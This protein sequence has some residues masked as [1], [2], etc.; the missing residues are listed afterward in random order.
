MENKK[1]LKL[2]YKIALIICSVLV[3]ANLVVEIVEMTDITFNMVLPIIGIL[4]MVAVL[5]Y[6]YIG[7]K[8][9]HGNLLRNAFF[10]YA[11]LDAAYIIACPATAP[12]YMI[13]IFMIEVVLITYMSGRLNKLNQ[14]KIIIAIVG[15]CTLVNGVCYFVR[16]PSISIIQLFHAFSS[17]IGW[18]TLSVAYISRY[19]AHTE[20]GLADK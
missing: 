5:Y 18:A 2:G 16:T 20:A 8:K 13:T 11:L 4:S 1:E 15:I 14:N 19:E 3:L 17:F 7:Y 12:K 10:I 6:A 9:P